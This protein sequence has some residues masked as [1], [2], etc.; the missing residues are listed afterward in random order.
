MIL[1]EAISEGS[2]LA[3]MEMM[4]PTMT[5][6]TANSMRVNPDL[7]AIAG[8]VFC[9]RQPPELRDLCDSPQEAR[10]ESILGHVFFEFFFNLSKQVLFLL[11]LLHLE[12]FHFLGDLMFL[13]LEFF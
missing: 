10:V 3:T 7:S 4:I 13:G 8:L 12:Q 1:D 2:T 9:D 5:I 11:G 6:T